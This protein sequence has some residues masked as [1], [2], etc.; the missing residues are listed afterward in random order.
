M[1]SNN[2]DTMHTDLNAADDRTGGDLGSLATMP[3]FPIYNSMS[4]KPSDSDEHA[5]SQ[6]MHITGRVE[7]NIDNDCPMATSQHDEKYAFADLPKLSD[8]EWDS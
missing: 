3:H 4:P 2:P 6:M 1:T 8:Q 5:S 7:L